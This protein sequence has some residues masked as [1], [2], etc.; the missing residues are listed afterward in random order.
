M[1]KREVKVAPGKFFEKKSKKNKSYTFVL[2]AAH[3]MAVINDDWFYDTVSGNW[4]KDSFLDEYIEKKKKRMEAE[5]AS[6]KNK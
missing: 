6:D 5:M 1:T 3:Y 4:V 2:E